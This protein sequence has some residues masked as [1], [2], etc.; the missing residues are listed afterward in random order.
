MENY[1]FDSPLDETR[2]SDE[3]PQKLVRIAWKRDAVKNQFLS[4][5]K[6]NGMTMAKLSKANLR[7]GIWKVKS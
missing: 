7:K 4:T 2:S 6:G 5:A 1:S 3:F